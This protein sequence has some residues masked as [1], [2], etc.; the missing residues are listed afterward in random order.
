MNEFQAGTYA[1]TI[2]LQ[3]QNRQSMASATKV[4]DIRWSGLQAQVQDIRKA[5]RQLRYVAK[6]EE[7]DRILNAGDPDERLAQFNSFWT[8]RDPTPGT[9]RNEAME[10]YYFRIKH[11]NDRFGLFQ[12]GWETDQGEVYI[13]FGEPS[14]VQRHPFD[15]GTSKP[16]EIWYYNNIGRKFIFVDDTGVGDYRLLRPIWDESTR[17]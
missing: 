6:N 11:V 13:R 16:Y 14:Y 5:V 1:I 4:F 2:T 8:K 10:E 7:I 9:R 3:G 17:M 12:E 15:F